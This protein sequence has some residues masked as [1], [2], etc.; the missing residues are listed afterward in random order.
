MR[1][2][3]VLGVVFFSTVSIQL[4]FASSYDTIRIA[5]FGIEVNSRINITQAV[6][7]ALQKAKELENPL[8]LF[9]KGRYDF[10]PQYANEKEYFESNTTDINPKRLG[11]LVEGFT[12][13]TIDGNGAEFV[14][15]DRMQPLTLDN[16]ANIKIR[17][18]TID[19][20]IPLTAQAEVLEIDDNSILLKIDKYESPY[21]IDKDKL[22]FVG[23]GWKSP[24]KGIMEI[25]RDSRLIAPATGDPGCCGRGW[26][27]AIAE[28]L[29]SGIV[30]ITKPFGLQRPDVG[31]L[32]DSASQ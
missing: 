28:E 23:E 13:L 2:F 8:L 1:F 21:I 32:F 30:K 29:E 9:E 24:M 10:W 6:N 4:C 22:I 14:F 15:H 27:K 12:N 17:N 26:D 31:E 5:E 11:I 20:D 25:T 16:S 19:W 3:K 18:F 7:H